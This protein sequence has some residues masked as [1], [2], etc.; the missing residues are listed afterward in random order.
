MSTLAYEIAAASAGPVIG[1]VDQL[2]AC[3]RS[4]EV[5]AYCRA[6]R[7]QMPTY[8]LNTTYRAA[9]AVL[10]YGSGP[11][12]E[13]AAHLRELLENT[14]ATGPVAAALTEDEYQVALDVERVRRWVVA[15]RS[16][17][18][19]TYESRQIGLDPLGRR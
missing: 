17:K 13:E 11:A 19:G 9:W 7:P 4:G 1:F 15:V 6:I 5:L 14:A 10:W 12:P 2:V 18:S 16:G 3:P 8:L